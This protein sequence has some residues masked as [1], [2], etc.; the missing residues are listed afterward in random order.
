MGVDRFDVDVANR[1]AL[2]LYEATLRDTLVT[3]CVAELDT[4]PIRVWLLNILSKEVRAAAMDTCTALTFEV[5]QTPITYWG[6]PAAR[7]LWKWA[8]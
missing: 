1:K 8:A 3:G 6:H 7:P 4:P 5:L 2:T